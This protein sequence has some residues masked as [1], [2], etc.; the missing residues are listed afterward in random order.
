MQCLSVPALPDDDHWNWEIKFDGFRT[1][2]VKVG[3]SVSLLSRNEKS[4]NAR[5]VEV[6]EAVA[7]LK[8]D[9]VLDGE[10]VAIDESGRPSF[11]LLQNSGSAAPP[12][13]FFCFDVLHYDGRSL[14]DQPIEARREVLES[15]VATGAGVVRLS[16][17]LSGAPQDVLA[18]VRELGLEGV[19][20]KRRGSLYQPGK[21]TGTWI[22]HRTNRGQEF[23]IG[24]YT[25]GTRG[26]DALLLGVFDAGELR[27]AGKVRNGFTPVIRDRI[28]P[29][30]KAEK[31]EACPFV[32]LPETGRSR[33]GEA[34]TKEKMRECRWLNPVLVCNVG[35]VE[36][37][38]G[39]K[40]RHPT[41]QGMRDDKPARKVVR[42]E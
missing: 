41:F 25:R 23:V 8:G 2:A 16:P 22:K 6:V 7:G 13:V 32:N 3:R 33:W 12:L 27:Y 9:F 29:T 30:L 4:L 5:F 18:A 34:L 39:G 31:V 36:W 19:V 10:V 28:F 14:V 1:E 37:T 38:D 20:G 24:G 42:E 21:R 40:L 26:F 15:I 11:Q 17:L 35:F